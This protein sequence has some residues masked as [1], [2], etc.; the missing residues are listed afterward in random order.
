M[1]S[2]QPV[3][4]TSCL[5]FPRPVLHV[6]RR[7]R[8]HKVKSVQHPPAKAKRKTYVDD[9]RSCANCVCVCVKC[10]SNDCSGWWLNQPI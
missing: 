1:F 2:S 3:D 6:E 10:F 4:L 5:L 7:S 8:S 9:L